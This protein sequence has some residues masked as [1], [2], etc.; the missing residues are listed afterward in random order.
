[1]IPRPAREFHR[2]RTDRPRGIALRVFL[3]LDTR[4]LAGFAGLVMR[5]I[6]F[7]VA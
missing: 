2:A 6:F 3:P 4:E 5:F 7:S 1:M